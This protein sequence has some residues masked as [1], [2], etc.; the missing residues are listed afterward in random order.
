MLAHFRDMAGIVRRGGSAGRGTLEP[1]D[2]IWVQFARSMAPMVQMQAQAL[3]ALVTEPGRPGRVLDVAAGHGLFGICVAMHN[4][5][6]QVVALD[7]ENVLEVARENAARFDVA[8]R[9]TTIAG[10]ALRL[11]SLND[12][13]AA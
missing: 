12:H 2:P 7:W 9:F 1:D 10:S 8:D 5:V 6:A 13:I 4:P 11:S 3:A